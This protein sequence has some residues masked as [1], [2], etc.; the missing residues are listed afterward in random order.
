MDRC[1]SLDTVPDKVLKFKVGDRVKIRPDKEIG[2]EVNGPGVG[3][4][5]Y[6][7]DKINALRTDRIVTISEVFVKP[8]QVGDYRV[9]EMPKRVFDE[10]CFEIYDPIESRFSILDL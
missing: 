3:Y 8:Y 5:G 1:G 2:A 4:F 7:D 6:L 9:E 10:V